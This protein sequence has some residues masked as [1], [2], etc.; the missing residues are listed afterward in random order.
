MVT[1]ALAPAGIPVTPERHAAH[2]YAKPTG[3]RRPEIRRCNT[4]F[5]QNTQ[6]T[7]AL[8]TF[9]NLLS[10]MGQQNEKCCACVG[11]ALAKIFAMRK[12]LFSDRRLVHLTR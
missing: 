3:F 5:D 9:L 12:I 7:A 8:K 6:R 2:F 4:S 11:S 10:E 1:I